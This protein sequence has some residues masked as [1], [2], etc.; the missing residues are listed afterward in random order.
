MTHEILVACDTEEGEAFIN[1]LNDQGH[2][3]E[4]SADDGNYID[5]VWTTTDVDA[6][7]KMNELWARYCSQ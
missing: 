7:M 5:G 1:W 6:N 4:M 3:A 2:G